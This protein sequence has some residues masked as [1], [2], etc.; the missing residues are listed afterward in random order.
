VNTLL[1]ELDGLS[2][3]KN[4]FVIAATNRPDMIDPAMIRPGR[5]DRLLYV[6]LPTPEER[7][8]ILKTLTRATPLSTEVDLLA[9]ANDVKCQGFSGAD[10][11]ALV[12]EAAV[13]ALRTTFSHGMDKTDTPESIHVTKPHFEV[14]LSRVFPSVSKKVLRPSMTNFFKD[15]RTY[16]AMSKRLSG[17][18]SR[19][20][21]PSDVE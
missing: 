8:E 20:T 17:L 11:S 14:A 19:L 6:D 21:A 7:L 16:Q 12:R 15:Y 13:T 5:L 18:R 9:I 10:L 2:G 4:V 1:T 3:R